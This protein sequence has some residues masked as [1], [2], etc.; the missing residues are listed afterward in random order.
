MS[1]PAGGQA[2]VLSAILHDFDDHDAAEIL[3]SCRRVM[4]DGARLLVIEEVISP[5]NAP[6]VSKFDDLHMFVL[7]GGRERTARQFQL[8]FEA[9]GFDLARVIA[10]DTPWS[11]IEGLLV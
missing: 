6:D 11:V 7:T 3:R 2:Y 5:G 10:T 9:A 4:G 1:V 8:L